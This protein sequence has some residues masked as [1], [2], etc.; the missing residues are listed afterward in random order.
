MNAMSMGHA[1]GLSTSRVSSVGTLLAGKPLVLPTAKVPVIVQSLTRSQI[2]A[3]PQKSIRVRVLGSVTEVNVRSAVLQARCTFPKHKVGVVVRGASALNGG[4]TITGENA[5]AGV[6]LLKSPSERE[7]GNPGLRHR[8]LARKA[9]HRKIQESGLPVRTLSKAGSDEGKLVAIIDNLGNAFSELKKFREEYREHN[10]G[11]GEPPHGHGKQNAGG[12]ELPRRHDIFFPPIDKNKMADCI[13]KIKDGFFGCEKTC[14][15]ADK[16]WNITDFCLLMFLAFGRMHILKN[17]SRQPFCLFLQDKVFMGDDLL[18][19]K[20]FNNYAN[21]TNYQT[22]EK[23]LPKLPFDFSSRLNE[24][25][26]SLFLACHE[27]GRAFHKSEYFR[28]LR[29]QKKNI[30]EF[31]L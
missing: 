12:D 27:I 17:L 23:E 29:T 7:R 10:G 25:N 4:I 30:G 15:L 26:N 11:G 18:K 2:L 16:S 31:V 28:S 14:T 24:H 13:L 9:L 5:I 19:V 22:L 6:K 3:L 8:V 21:N 1:R 20:N